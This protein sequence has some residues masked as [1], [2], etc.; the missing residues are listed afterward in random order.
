MDYRAKDGEMRRVHRETVDVLARF[1]RDG[2]FQRLPCHEGGIVVAGG[3]RR[4]AAPRPR[5]LGRFVDTGW[6][7]SRAVHDSRGQCSE[8]GPFPAR[9]SRGA[10]PKG[11][12]RGFSDTWRANIAKA[13]SFWMHGGDM[14]PGRGAFPVP[15]PFWDTWS[16]KLAKDC[17]PGTH[18]GKILPR[19]VAW[20]RIARAYCHCRMPGN[21]FREHFAIGERP[22]RHSAMYR[23]VMRRSATDARAERSRPC[24]TRPTLMPP[25]RPPRHY[26]TMRRTQRFC[27][28]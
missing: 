16:A 17:R 24:P 14:L 28:R 4:S 6:Q 15:G 2:A 11:D 7:D 20:E 19:I 27:R 25:P 3:S 21:A 9:S 13:S 1:G 5:A 18:R 26:G 10:F 8:K 22:Q 23:N 12:L